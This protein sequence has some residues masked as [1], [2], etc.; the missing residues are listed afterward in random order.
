SGPVELGR[1][2]E[3]EP[4]P[5]SS[6]PTAGHQRIVLAGIDEGG[7][8]RKHAWL[9]P[10]PDG[11]V[12]LANESKTRPIHFPDGTEL[13]PGRSRTLT[14][15]LSLHIGSRVVSIESDDIAPPD[16]HSLPVPPV[17]PGIGT[18][19]A[20]LFLTVAG[21]AATPDE[22]LIR[23][24][25]GAMGVLQSAASSL[26]FFDRAAGALVELVGL[27]VGRVWLREK[28]QWRVQALKTALRGAS[29]DL[30]PSRQILGKVL[31][32]KRTFWQVPPATAGSLVGVKALVAA[33]ILDRRG[34]VIGIL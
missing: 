18:A 13:G 29:Q 27:D 14:L 32:E 21:A 30:Q 19:D 8:S 34:D 1:Q 4:P 23:W 31:Q 16:L 12:L 11:Q 7:V 15:P 5:Y 9:K 26:D 10:L 6:T 33:P 24:F 17:R 25:Q 28:G 2:S 20:S 3:G 22:S